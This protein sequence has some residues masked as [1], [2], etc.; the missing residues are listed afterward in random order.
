MDHVLITPAT[1]IK[2]RLV[3]CLNCGTEQDLDANAGK[4]IS[5]V[6]IGYCHDSNTET[7]QDQR[8][9]QSTKSVY[10]VS[11]ITEASAR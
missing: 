7:E 1:A 11:R 4:N 10:E 8:L 9:Y 2:I 6:G 3:Q 5:T